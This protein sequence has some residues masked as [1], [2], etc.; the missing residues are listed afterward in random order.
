M[1]LH[2]RP[3]EHNQGGEGP[4]RRIILA[5]LTSSVLLGGAD[6]AFAECPTFAQAR[7][8]NPNSYLSYHVVAGAHCWFAGSPHRRE[9]R[10]QS[11]REVLSV[12]RREPQKPRAQFLASSRDASSRDA[13][14]RDSSPR[15]ASS[16]DASSRD[17]PSRDSSSRDASSRDTSKDERPARGLRGETQREAQIDFSNAYELDTVPPPPA[18]GAPGEQRIARTFNSVG[19]ASGGASAIEYTEWKNAR[20]EAV[21]DALYGPLAAPPADESTPPVR[22]A[23]R[24]AKALAWILLTI[25]IGS[26][27]IGVLQSFG[28]RINPPR[29]AVAASTF[30]AQ[31][32]WPREHASV[33]TPLANSGVVERYGVV[34]PSRVEARAAVEPAPDAGR[35]CARAYP[36]VRT[37]LVS[38]IAYLEPNGSSAWQRARHHLALA[39]R[40]LSDWL[41]RIG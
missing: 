18:G 10:E 32:L 20:L 25:G 17:A 34:L 39:R 27:G 5:T 3:T 22:T 33:H 29:W 36:S 7:A 23:A 16:R 37:P 2:T 1:N 38:F 11:E 35:L 28:D 12:E 40:S 8:A 21:R 9:L 30:N 41:P 31:R 24:Y 4:V 14:S 19:G 26:L 13:P 15:D 6:H